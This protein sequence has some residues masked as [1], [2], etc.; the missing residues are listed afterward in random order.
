MAMVERV[1]EC[2]SP[3]QYDLFGEGDKVMAKIDRRWVEGQIT[4]CGSKRD[5]Y[6][7]STGGVL[8]FKVIGL[9]CIKAYDGNT[10]EVRYTHGMTKGCLSRC[11]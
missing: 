4:G 2:R 7:I 9:G 3:D 1:G 6:W 8:Y 5:T 10:F 11:P